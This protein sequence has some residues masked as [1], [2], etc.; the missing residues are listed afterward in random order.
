MRLPRTF[1]ESG[2]VARGSRNALTVRLLDKKSL[3]F[4]RRFSFEGSGSSQHGTGSVMSWEVCQAICLSC[5]VCSAAIAT[6]FP[7]VRKG[8][9]TICLTNHMSH[10]ADVLGSGQYLDLLDGR[11]Q[12]PHPVTGSSYQMRYSAQRTSES[13]VCNDWQKIV[14]NS[15]SCVPVR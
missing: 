4:V 10:F 15:P 9:V 6:A 7:E 8:D 3:L 5:S 1:Q 11:R 2:T 14:A 12:E 13:L